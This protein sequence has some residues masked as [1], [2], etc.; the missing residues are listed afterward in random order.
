MR[1]FKI[2]LLSVVLLVGG[3]IF[4]LAVIYPATWH[5]ETRRESIRI[6]QAAHTTP[7]LTNAVGYLGW[8]VQ[9][10][11]HEWIAIR[12]RDTHSGFVGSSSV[13]RDSGGEWFESDR[14]FCGRFQFWPNLKLWV[15]AEEEQRKLTPH[16]FT[17][18]V[19]LADNDDEAGSFPTYRE[20]M[21]IESAPDLESARRGLLQ[22]GFKKLK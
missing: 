10:T 17:N 14:H 21:A 8:F 13:A 4:Y 1:V 19:S 11:N 9:L 15:Q 6:L 12:Y 7:E 16:L 5:Y 20:L 22:I 18:R 2:I 3:F